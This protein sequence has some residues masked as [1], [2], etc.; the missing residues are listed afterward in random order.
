MRLSRRAP[1][2]E[3]AAIDR[4]DGRARCR[5]KRGFERICVFAGEAI[6]FT[7]S[8]RPDT[9]FPESC[10]HRFHLW[11]LACCVAFNAHPA[12]AVEYAQI[13][14]TLVKEPVYVHAP[15]YAL[16]LFGREAR[17]RVWLVDGGKVVSPPPRTPD[18][19]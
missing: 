1:R 14:R 13:D 5:T 18:A 6:E 15:D 11:F 16:L 17:L 12:L 10:M 4:I 7:G 19:E 8:T 2:R 3:G 9:H